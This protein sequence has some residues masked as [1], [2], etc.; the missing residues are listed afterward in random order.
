MKQLLNL[1]GHPVPEGVEETF[2]VTSVSVPNIELAQKGAVAEASRSLVKQALENA[3]VEEALL[4]GEAVV[5][6][7][8]MTA[9]AVGVLSVLTGFSGSFPETRTVVRTSEGFKLSDDLGLGELKLAGRAL[10]N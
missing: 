8:G 5:L 9:L 4:Y 1:S 6:L 2:K 3:E 10:R 7:P